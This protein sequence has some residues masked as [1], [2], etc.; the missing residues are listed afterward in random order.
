MFFKIGVSIIKSVGKRY[1]Q[2]YVKER[3]RLVSARGFSN[4]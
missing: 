3:Q 1:I 4:F 2:K